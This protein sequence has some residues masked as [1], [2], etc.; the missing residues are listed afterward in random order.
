MSRNLAL[1]ATFAAL[2][3]ALG[4]TPAIVVPGN[5]V[6]ITL[7]SFGVM[8]AGLVLGARRGAAAVLVFLFLVAIGLPILPGG[9]GGVGVFAGPTAGFLLGFPLAALVIG[10]LIRLRRRPTLWWTWLSTLL[11]GVGVV[12]LCGVPVQAARVGTKTLG[13]TLAASAIYLPG[14]LI[15]VTLAALVATA[16]YRGYPQ[17]APHADVTSSR[18]TIGV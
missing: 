4:L 16:V 10:V 7:Q 11:G 12:Y 9:R 13:Q 3:A 14:D 15:K 18:P 5:P 1:V 2:I 17:A 6:P 8:I